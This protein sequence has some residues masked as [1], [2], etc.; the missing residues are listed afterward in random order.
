MTPD[1]NRGERCARRDKSFG[2]YG[3]SGNDIVVLPV[4]RVIAIG[5]AIGGGKPKEKA[6]WNVRIRC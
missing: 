2:S 6:P 5:G 3:S 4:Q 1:R